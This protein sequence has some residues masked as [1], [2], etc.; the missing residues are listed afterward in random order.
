MR[1][2]AFIFFGVILASGIVFARP[3]D[4]DDLAQRVKIIKKYKQKIW[5]ETAKM[6]YNEKKQESDRPFPVTDPFK[7]TFK[8]LDSIPFN[9]KIKQNS[10]DYLKA[11]HTGGRYGNKS[12]VGVKDF[13]IIR[14]AK[15]TLGYFVETEIVEY[16]RANHE[17]KPL[18]DLTKQLRDLLRKAENELKEIPTPSTSGEQG[19]GMTEVEAGDSLAES[20][21]STLPVRQNN[22]IPKDSVKIVEKDLDAAIKKGDT[23]N[24][25]K[26]KDRLL[27]TDK[28]NEKGLDADQRLKEYKTKMASARK[29]W[30]ENQIVVA[31]DLFRAA[32]MN[33]GTQEAREKI[34]EIDNQ[35]RSPMTWPWRLTVWILAGVLFL[36]TGLVVFAFF[37]VKKMFLVDENEKKKLKEE[38]QNEKEY[39]NSKIRDLEAA[40]EEKNAEITEGNDKIQSLRQQLAAFRKDTPAESSGQRSPV[41]QPAP[42]SMVRYATYKDDPEGF[43]VASLKDSRDAKTIFE[44]RILGQSN[45]EFRVSKETDP[46]RYA[47]NSTA[48]FL[49]PA[50]TYDNSPND[51]NF[52]ETLVPGKLQLAG[53]TWRIIDK[54]VIRFK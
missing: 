23:V 39:L 10:I 25:R 33:V 30:S 40:N 2:L 9:E 4:R 45:A 24:L 47:L 29:A 8:V 51:G 15:G 36:L 3:A 31:Y 46:Q 52:I 48:Y 20:P 16:L 54:A 26:F 22:P 28:N 49:E 12:F 19:T 42:P 6:L 35:I 14:G 38:V 5:F 13:T 34:A 53:S 32:A 17:E 43:S 44:I 1:R 37:K 7:L 50:C 18:D 11:L 21:T 27:L 41:V